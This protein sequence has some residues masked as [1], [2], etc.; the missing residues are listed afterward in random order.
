KPF[1]PEELERRV[2]A[3]IERAD[4]RKRALDA[5][6]DALLMEIH[7]G[8]SASLSRAAM[9]L[10]DRSATGDGAS[11]ATIRSVIAEGLDE[12]R[13]I[14]RLLA[15]RA[16][17]FGLLCAE[18][19]RAMAD[20]CRAASIELD[21]EASGAEEDAPLEAPVAHALRRVAREATTNVIKHAGA[22]RVR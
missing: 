21:F 6:R 9:L 16:S 17:S 14:A 4:A 15:P 20:A 5:Q 12:V 10:V 13:S 3:A 7:D 11:T 8:V 19:R 22:R 1:S 18:I 2:L